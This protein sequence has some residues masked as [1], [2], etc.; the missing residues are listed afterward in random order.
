MHII[1]LYEVIKNSPKIRNDRTEIL[2]QFL[3]LPGF[4]KHH[5]RCEK[6]WAKQNAQMQ[7]TTEKYRKQQKNDLEKMIA[8]REEGKVLAGLVDKFYRELKSENKQQESIF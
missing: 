6:I 8:I 3:T 2:D 5:N 1:R 7:K 4:Q